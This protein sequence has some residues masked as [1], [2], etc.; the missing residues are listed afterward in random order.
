MKK[1]K[2]LDV[3]ALL[4]DIPEQKLI[5][6]QVGTIV[7][8][9]QNNVFEVEFSSNAGEAIATIPVNAENLLLLHYE[10]EPA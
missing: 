7:E 8:Q 10:A 1:F 4:K 6:G 5:K 9:L 2:I 3:V